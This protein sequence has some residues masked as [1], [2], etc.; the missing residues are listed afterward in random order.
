MKTADWGQP[1]DFRARIGN[2]YRQHG[3]DV[4][5][6][7]SL[8]GIDLQL[9]MI[10]DSRW[11]TLEAE[12]QKDKP[13]RLGRE[14]TSSLER[15]DKT[16][17]DFKHDELATFLFTTLRVD[18]ELSR[19]FPKTEMLIGIECSTG[20]GIQHLPARDGRVERQRDACA[21]LD[22]TRTIEFT[23]FASV[24]PLGRSLTTVSP[25]AGPATADDPDGLK[26]NH[27]LAAQ[28][29]STAPMS[30]AVPWLRGRPRWSVL[31]VE[32]RTPALMARLPW[33][34]I[35]VNVGPPLSASGPSRGFVLIRS[36]ALRHTRG[37][38]EKRLW[39][40]D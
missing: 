1:A 9:W 16:W 11:D 26:A 12:I 32:I 31:T 20:C 17:T 10:D 24:K 5:C 35:W 7:R 15:F 19:F 36:V 39:P 25:W 22:T 8:D 4:H 3:I 21:R 2:W 29:T 27:R 34:G 6:Q 23:P 33:S 14:A 37:L 30:V 18:G 13:L 38:S 40:R 28:C